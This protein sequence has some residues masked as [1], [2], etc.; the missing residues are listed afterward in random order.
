MDRY[1]IYCGAYHWAGE[2]LQESD[3]EFKRDLAM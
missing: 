1:C 2:Q 3:K